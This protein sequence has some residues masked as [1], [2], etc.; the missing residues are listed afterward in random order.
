[1]TSDQ[2]FHNM[3]LG[4]FQ[5]V[6]KTD[7][8]FLTIARNKAFYSNLFWVESLMYE[9]MAKHHAVDWEKNAKFPGES[10]MSTIWADL[11]TNHSKTHD[12][13]K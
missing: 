4:Q 10:V 9:E 2:S 5:S 1:M 3:V 6:P 7:M 8:K 12:L 13:T 11:Q